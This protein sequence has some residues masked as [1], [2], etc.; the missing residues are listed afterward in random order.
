M[1]I[2]NLISLR[3]RD[4]ET[5]RSTKRIRFPITWIFPYK[6]EPFEI[7]SWP[8]ATMSRKYPF[9]S[10][11][12]N[13]YFK[14]IQNIYLV[15]TFAFHS[16]LDCGIFLWNVETSDETKSWTK[17]WV[18][19]SA[20]HW[21]YSHCIWCSI[22]FFLHIRLKIFSEIFII[23]I[24][25]HWNK[26]HILTTMYEEIRVEAW[27]EHI[28]SLHISRNRKSSI[29]YATILGCSSVYTV[30]KIS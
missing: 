16:H 10:F 18:R 25:V 19:R 9:I 30:L 1:N 15:P 23:A 6:F 22:G 21:A 20:S 29:R 24:T 14:L 26:S 17:C 2:L 8:T 5:D 13:I 28:E 27:H 11:Y 12:L 7:L 4:R 3:A